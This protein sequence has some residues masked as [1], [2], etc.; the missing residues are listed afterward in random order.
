MLAAQFRDPQIR[1][2]LRGPG[3]LVSRLQVL[4]RVI[5]CYNWVI[6]SIYITYN[7]T[8]NLLTKSPGPL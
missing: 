7:S 5:I 8:S 3:N 1:I 2:L 4:S 6:I